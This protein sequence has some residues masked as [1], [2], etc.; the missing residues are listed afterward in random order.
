LLQELEH[1]VTEE[2]EKWV[3]QVLEKMSPEEIETVSRNFC[4]AKLHEP[5]R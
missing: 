2:E 5:T 1:H 4:S 3:P